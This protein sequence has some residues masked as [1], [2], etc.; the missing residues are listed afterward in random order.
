[1]SDEFTS[2][3]FH[4][5]FVP[6]PSAHPASVTLAFLLLL[7]HD[8][9]APTYG[10]STNSSQHVYADN[11][12]PPYLL[13]CHIFNKAYPDYP[14]KNYNPIIPIAL[15]TSQFTW[16]SCSPVIGISPTRT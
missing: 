7:E 10:L 5:P 15:N 3:P 16:L 11:S 1:M 2:E 8:N 6:T 9:T 4:S 14:I 12:S 13:K